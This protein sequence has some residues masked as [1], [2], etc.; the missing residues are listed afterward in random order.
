[1]KEEAVLTKKEMQVAELLA[2]G[3]EKKEAADMLCV[4]YNTIVS[5]AR[6]IY[7]KLGIQKSTELSVWYFC[8]RFHIS[9]NL[10]PI[11]RRFLAIFLLVVTGIGAADENTD[12][13]RAFRA[14]RT[15]SVRAA[16]RTKRDDEPTNFYLL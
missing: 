10:S 9:F 7:E 3:A 12:M 6:S 8:T 1:M 11:A 2:W 14:P 15:V 13:M 5:H 16:R 4:S